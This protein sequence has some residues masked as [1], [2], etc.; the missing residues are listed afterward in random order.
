MVL[1][2]GLFGVIK[3]TEKQQHLQLTYTQQNNASGR[4]DQRYRTSQKHIRKNVTPELHL[5]YSKSGGNLG[6]V[7]NDKK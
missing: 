7:L 6:L 2:C 5:T 1:G 3:L 4:T